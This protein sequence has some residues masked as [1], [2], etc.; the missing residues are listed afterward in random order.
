M[1]YMV[2]DLETTIRNRGDESIG[3][4]AASPFHPDNII[5]VGGS[6]DDAGNIRTLFS[7][8]PVAPPTTDILLVGQNIAFDLLYLMSDP[9]WREWLKTGRIWDTMLV[10]YLISGQERKYQSLDALSVRYGGTV[11]PDRIKE[12][13]EAGID[14]PDIPRDEL[15]EYL[16]G[17]LNN[18]EIV[19]LAQLEEADRLNMV[20]LIATQM[21]ARLATVEMEWNGM[22][23]DKEI[24]EVH[25]A[26]LEYSIGVLSRRIIAEME[27][28]FPAIAHSVLTP[29]SSQQ[30][31]TM[32]FGGTITIDVQEDT[33]TRYKTGKRAGE[34]KLK[35]EKKIITIPQL[36]DGDTYSTKGKNG[37]WRVDVG[38]LTKI[39]AGALWA[40]P[41]DIA[42]QLLQY[43]TLIKDL[44]TYYR[45]YSKLLWPTDSCMHP[46]YSHCATDTGRLSCSKPNLQQA[47]GK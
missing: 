19:F 6:K 36:L 37:M 10:E 39:V 12:Y 33:G 15:E 7:S 14:T 16:I 17:D 26:A 25:K 5:V 24:L 38:V 4:F 35:R 11:K 42:K 30:I 40:T 1:H 41:H 47:S 45:G 46:S 8:L 22:Y 44:T 13:W 21:E 3:D 18:T 43:R 27:K 20:P 23:V 29:N 31:G 28:H 9:E 2:I 32:L 34:P